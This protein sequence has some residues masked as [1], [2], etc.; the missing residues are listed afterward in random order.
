MHALHVCTHA[1]I[2]N[3]MVASTHDLSVSTSLRA[4]DVSDDAISRFVS[5]FDT[6]LVVV[7]ITA[8]ALTLYIGLMYNARHA[9]SQAMCAYTMHDRKPSTGLCIQAKA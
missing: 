4:S 6:V 9:M 5:V 1:A 2:I 3:K 7:N 8:Y